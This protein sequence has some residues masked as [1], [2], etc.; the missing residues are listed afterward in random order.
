MSKD[1]FTH[2]ILKSFQ[3]TL[4]TE[5]QQQLEQW[6]KEDAT[7]HELFDKLE[8]SWKQAE[9]YKE[10][11]HVDLD[12][13]WQSIQS[14]ISEV[15]ETPRIIPFWQLSA[16]RIAASLVLLIGIGWAALNFFNRDHAGQFA[17]HIT[18]SDEVKEIS[19][20]DGTT[21]W[22]NENSEISYPEKFN[23]RDV[24]L[25]G[26]AEFKVTHDA[27]NPFTVA[28]S[29]TKTTVLGTT[30]NVDATN[31]MVSVSLIEGRI[32]F[33]SP[34]EEEVILAPGE[35]AS[36][37]AAEGVLTQQV[38]STQNFNSWKT[39]ELDFDQQPLEVVVDDLEEYFEI[40][41]DLKN[42][43]E[44]A[45]LFTGT[46]KEPSFDE[47]LDVLSFTFS[48]NHSEREGTSQLVIHSCQ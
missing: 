5:E 29:G 47:I 13:G 14:R 45:C 7:H 30:F 34:E 41:I 27:T 2:L 44:E 46:F 1:L 36:Y 28:A 18:S 20:P 31:E 33:A 12:K 40:N 26:E 32:A 10:D 35:T 6:L 43:S 8:T 39:G 25:S 37:N 38:H 23:Q 11:F 48:L 24:N 22:L 3:G 16:V 17:T 21:V 9:S 4:T 15:K 19:L 42:E